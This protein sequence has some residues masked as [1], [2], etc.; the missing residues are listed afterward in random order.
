[1][2]EANDI[3]YGETFEVRFL[4]GRRRH[5]PRYPLKAPVEF[6]IVMGEA[7]DSTQ[8][9]GEGTDI[10]LGGV[11]VRLPQ[12]NKDV[13]HVGARV[14]LHLDVEGISEPL[15]I[16]GVVAHADAQHGFGISFQGLTSELRKRLKMLLTSHIATK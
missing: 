3:V 9:R 16:E 10:S 11:G 15:T 4:W 13:P 8:A 12:T 2:P 5:Y 7:P 14:R 1:M 6:T